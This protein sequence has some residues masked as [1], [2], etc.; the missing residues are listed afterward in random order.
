MQV[1][2]AA[3]QKVGLKPGDVRRQATTLISGLLVGTLREPEG[4]RSGRL[5]RSG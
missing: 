3:A 2:L 5:E 4:L 1:N